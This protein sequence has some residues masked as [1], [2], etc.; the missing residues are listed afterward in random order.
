MSLQTH[1]N[2]KIPLD[3]GLNLFRASYKDHVRESVA[4]LSIPSFL[5]MPATKRVAWSE[6]LLIVWKLRISSLKYVLSLMLPGKVVARRR[7]H[8]TSEAQFFI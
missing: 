3:L 7:T 4:S 6:V 8:T 2:M 5:C 1:Q